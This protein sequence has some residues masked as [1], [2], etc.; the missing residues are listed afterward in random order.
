MSL[1]NPKYK[2]GKTTK[3]EAAC[4]LGKL[5]FQVEKVYA[6]LRFKISKGLGLLIVYFKKAVNNP[7]IKKLAK[8]GNNN[9]LFLNKNNKLIA[10]KIKYQ[11]L[12]KLIN[13]KKLCIKSMYLYPVRDRH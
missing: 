3:T 8:K 7:V 12:K 9:F 2:K 5:E 13:I 11:L 6:T 4:Q 10:I 1:G